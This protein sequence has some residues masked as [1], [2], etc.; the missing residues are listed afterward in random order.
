MTNQPNVLFVD[1]E[2]NVLLAIHRMLKPRYRLTLAAAADAALQHLEETDFDVIVSDMRMPGMDGNEFLRR[3]RARRPDAVRLV[4]SGHSDL[5]AA[6]RAIND[7][8]I[9]RFLIKP[10]GRDALVGALEAALEQRRLLRAEKELLE[11]TVTGSIDA[12]SELLSFANPASFGRS[13]RLKRIVS[14]LATEAGLARRWQLEVAASFSQLGAVCLSPELAARLDQGTV[15]TEAERSLAARAASVPT[16]IL[17]RIP[18]LDGVLEL[19]EG[20]SAGAGGSLEVRTLRAA[21][22]VERRLS[23]GEPIEQ[24]LAALES[25]GLVDPT[26]LVALKKL[27][28][29]LVGEGPHREVSVQALQ[30]GMVFADDVLTQSGALL[31]TKGHEVSEGLMVRL[32]SFAST[33]GIREPLR[34]FFIEPDARAA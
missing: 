24:V 2:E 1:D 29:L 22:M 14:L 30:P 33:V 6:A 16:Q 3:A 25:G 13:R 10:A 27:R 23:A 28:K 20:L 31:I 21:A 11:R 34:V 7:G 12:L 8:H 17:Q 26:L 5:E 9:F 19:L 4:L 18:R 32:R 15:L